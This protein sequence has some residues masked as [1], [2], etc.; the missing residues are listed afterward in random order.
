MA[1]TGVRA[2]KSLL[3]RFCR[4]IIIPNSGAYPLRFIAIPAN[5]LR[6]AAL[7]SGVPFGI[8]I[9]IA[10]AFPFDVAVAVAVAFF[11]ASVDV[12]VEVGEPPVEVPPVDGRD[13]GGLPADG[14]FT[15]KV[16]GGP[17]GSSLIGFFIIGLST[18][19]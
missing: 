7:S 19:L 14:H 12:F 16:S 6:T 15:S 3:I 1:K 4:A 2:G 9:A 13:G 10:G 17:F 11:V 8:A 5:F 18:T